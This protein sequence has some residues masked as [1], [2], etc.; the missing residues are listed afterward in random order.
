MYGRIR[1]VVHAKWVHGVNTFGELV[2]TCSNC[3]S[4]LPS[5]IVGDGTVDHP[6]P[7]VEYIEETAYC[8]SCGAKMD[9]K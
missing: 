5:V 4:E 7:E 3:Q 6:Y 2:C 1:K 8:P 9:L